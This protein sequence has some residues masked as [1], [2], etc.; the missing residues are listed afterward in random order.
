VK[1]KAQCSELG[2]LEFMSTANKWR[3]SE[4]SRDFVNNV[5]IRYRVYLPAWFMAVFSDRAKTMLVN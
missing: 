1:L 5:P 3:T 2:K 4:A